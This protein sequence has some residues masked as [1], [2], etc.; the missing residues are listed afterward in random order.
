MDL[1]NIY[2][3]HPPMGDQQRR[4]GELGA[5]AKAQAELVIKLVPASAE[6]TLALRRLEE[7][8]M[9]A[10]AA[11]ARNEGRGDEETGEGGGD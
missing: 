4:Y 1:D 5:G 2:T 10:A 11:I 6:R 9:W 8:F 7:S 3:Y